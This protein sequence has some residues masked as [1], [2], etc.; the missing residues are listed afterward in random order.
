MEDY[1]HKYIKYKTKYLELKSQLKN[2]QMGG[3]NR[4]VIFHISGPSGAG[5]TTLGNKLKERFGNYIVVVDID[6]LRKD[7]V[8]YRYGGYNKVWGKQNFKWDHR[9]YQKYI[10]KFVA[11]QTKPLVFVGLNHMPWWHKKLYY[12]MHGDYN[13][14]IKLDSDTIFKQKC[15]RLIEKF[16]NEKDIIIKEIMDNEKE[17]VKA[18]QNDIKYECGYK[19]T[20]QMNN[21]WNK[22]YQKQGYKI[23]SREKILEEVI[24]KLNRIL[25]N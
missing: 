6:D 1:Y 16:T 3:K 8:K 4:E 7:F 25:D 12:N 9:S 5:K 23:M 10:D 13:Y 11:K 17:T 24:E 14:Y 18:L 2:K 22:D 20:T 21:I 19:E 15:G